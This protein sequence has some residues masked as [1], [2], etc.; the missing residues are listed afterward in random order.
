M[1]EINRY[2]REASNIESVRMRVD[3][4]AQKVVNIYCL[5]SCIQVS[6]CGRI[7][8]SSSSYQNKNNSLQICFFRMAKEDCVGRPR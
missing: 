1:L 2:I 5:V 8:Q 6:E 4:N 7:S 3:W